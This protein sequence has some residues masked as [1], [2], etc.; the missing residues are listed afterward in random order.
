MKCEIC[1]KEPATSLSCL[2]YDDRDF[3][4]TTPYKTDP[5]KWTGSC[6]ADTEL[7][8]ITLDRIKTQKD[9]THWYH[10]LR[11]KVWFGPVSQASFLFKLDDLQSRL[12][13]KVVASADPEK[14][15]R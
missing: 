8:Y 7:Y 6:T 4:W 1:K 14:W 12:S 5:W 15:R 3:K 9:A 10:H 11:E 2:A 13:E